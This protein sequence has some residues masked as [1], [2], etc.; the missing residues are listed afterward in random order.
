MLTKAGLY[1]HT[2]KYLKPVQ[3]TARVRR[4]LI[5]PRPN[6]APA[7]EPRVAT[8]P[9][10]PPTAPAQ[11]LFDGPVFDFLGEQGALEEI[12]WD[13]EQRSKLWR[14]N[15]HYFADLIA[16]GAGGRA[17]A[18]RVL[19][20]DWIRANPPG[21]GTGWEAY[22]TSLRIVNWIKW[23]LVGNTLPDGAVHSLAAQ[24]R[25]LS[26][27]LEWHLLGNHLFA[28]AKALVFAGLFFDGAEAG[29]W[30]R[31]GLA[32]LA[33]EVPEQILPDGGQ[34]ELS[35][36]YHALALEDML[37]L[38]NIA[39]C[40][41]QGLPPAGQAQAEDWATRLPA[42]QS[43]LTAMSHP[44]GEVAFFNDA[45]IGIAPSPAALAAY[46]ARLGH[47]A[48]E[49]PGPLTWLKDSGYARLAA[50]PAVLLA[51]IGRVGPDYIPGHAHADTLSIEISLFGQRVFVNSGTSVY[52]KGP[53][54]QRQ[55]GTLAHNTVCLDGQNSSE[56]WDGF[57]VAR[58]ARPRDVSVTQAD[59]TL[60]ISAAHDG[61]ARLPGRPLHRRE[62]AL[63]GGRLQINDDVTPATGRIGGVV[64]YHL[65][66]DVRA[67]I[68]GPDTGEL[69]LPGEMV[70][71]WQARG[72]ATRLEPATWH[73]RFGQ[74]QPNTCLVV[75]LVGGAAG[76]T[77]SFAHIDLSSDPVQGTPR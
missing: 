57:R 19:I 54:R 52:G 3:F 17:E 37:D 55:R 7:P 30:L 50:G 63:S 40:Y 47:L 23:S 32:I 21:Q 61:Y 26:D 18:Q 5:R 36:M 68:T 43:W 71:P 49:A 45:A 51:D 1:W 15:Q 9:W 25:W 13:G 48:S 72:G 66:P 41:G 31:T 8:G 38:V 53:E 28:N 29:G 22:P 2:L 46:A 74:S 69:I 56:V 59:D 75:E 34:F 64:R 10:V 35:P 6:T 33:D 27:S 24:A 70:L 73:P 58:R 65:H 76:L 42:M 44:D 60:Q 62:I 67:R 39:A 4:K 16:E 12:G 11:S 77:L 14:Y 20:E